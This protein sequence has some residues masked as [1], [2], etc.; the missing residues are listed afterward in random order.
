[1]VNLELDKLIANL[2]SIGSNEYLEKIEKIRKSLIKEDPNTKLAVEGFMLKLA[3]YVPELAAQ[4]ERINNLKL[5][6]FLTECKELLTK[7][8]PKMEKIDPSLTI[9]V[10]IFLETIEFND[11]YTSKSEL[12]ER[13][14]NFIDNLERVK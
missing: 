11:I 14:Q 5:K 12:S 7:W 4:L 6:E 2:T 3:F 8:F 10:T 9:V 13:I 1:M